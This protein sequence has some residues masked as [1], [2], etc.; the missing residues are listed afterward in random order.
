MTDYTPS[1]EVQSQIDEMV[2]V[3][4]ARNEVHGRMTGVTGTRAAVK[5]EHDGSATFIGG[6]QEAERIPDDGSR[7]LGRELANIDAD[8]AAL[9]AKV[10][11]V[12]YDPATGKPSYVLS[13]D[14]RAL[15][16]MQLE[17][18]KAARQL[19]EIQFPKIEAQRVNDRAWQEAEADERVR[20]FAL[21]GGNPAVEARLD[22]ILQEEELRLG[23]KA[24][25]ATRYERINR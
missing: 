12:V 9:S 2:S 21:T 1:A 14:Q 24:L 13:E 19:A 22:A 8:I 10:E 25:L 17:S 16:L 5:I 6:V 15:V 18:R 23:A 4:G 7:D 11:A 20:R 3:A